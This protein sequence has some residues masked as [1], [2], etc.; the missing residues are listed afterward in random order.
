MHKNMR[1]F[2]SRG[3]KKA[4]FFV[5]RGALMPAVLVE[6]GYITNSQE[7]ASLV[8]EGYQNTISA[9]VGDGIVEFVRYFNSTN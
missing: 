7:R 9:S 5:L 1:S 3:V 6:A 8:K 2:K 4:N